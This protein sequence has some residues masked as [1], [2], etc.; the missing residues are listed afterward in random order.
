MPQSGQGVF[1][2]EVTFEGEEVP[3]REQM[4]QRP[5]GR[6]EPGVFRSSREGCVAGAEKVDYEVG[7]ESRDWIWEGLRAKW[8]IWILF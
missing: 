8:R 3:G 6:K 1:S 5:R 7:R 4:V 2:E